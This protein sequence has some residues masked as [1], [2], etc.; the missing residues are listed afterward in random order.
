MPLSQVTGKKALWFLF[1]DGVT[2]RSSS[3]SLTSENCKQMEQVI[4]GYLRHVW[5]KNNWLYDEQLGFRPGYCCESQVITV[6]Q[7]IA[8]S[9]DGG[10][11]ETR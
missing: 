1:T 3:I 10:S 7:D 5:D 11:V 2:D 9:L 6:Y 4:A 8:D